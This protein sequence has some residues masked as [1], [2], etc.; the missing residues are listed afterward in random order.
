M[1]YP[2][3]FMDYIV[4]CIGYAVGEIYLGGYHSTV[5]FDTKPCKGDEDTPE[6]ETVASVDTSTTYLV[7]RVTVYPAALALWK[8]GRY[9][10]L[11]KLMLHE[12]CHVLT[13]PLY[14]WAKMDAA[15]SQTWVI[16]DV[17]EQTTERIAKTIMDLLPKDWYLPEKL[18][19]KKTA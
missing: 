9:E 5:V 4:A 2:K 13:Q 17:N 1:R 11:S 12:V 14:N 15:P 19:P 6:L 8:E 16:R 18:I 10:R 3:K 7:F